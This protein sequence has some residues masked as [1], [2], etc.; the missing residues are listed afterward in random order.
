MNTSSSPELI[1]LVL[2]AGLTGLIWL[3]Y[4]ANR[5]IEIGMWR[6]LSNPK[7]DGPPTKKWAQR[8]IHAHENAVENLVVFAALVLA[9]QL[10]HA[11]NEITAMAAMVFFYAR[12]THLIVYTMGIPVVRTLA[13]FVGFI[14]EA[15]LF[16]QFF[17]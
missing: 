2:S 10:S 14:C 5:M 13:F 15:V 8:I 4:I 11:N 7:A 9:I 17:S 1:Y 16:I 12:L 6:T 3:A